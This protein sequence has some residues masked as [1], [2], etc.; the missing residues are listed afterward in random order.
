VRAAIDGRDPRIALLPVEV[1]LPRDV[2]RH[3]LVR[4]LEAEHRH[5]RRVHVEEAA[6]S[7]GTED[8]VGCPVD[9]RT[10]PFLRL[11]KR[12]LRVL[13]CLNVARDAEES[14]RDA[15]VVPQERRVRLHPDVRPVFPQAPPLHQRR[16]TPKHGEVRVAGELREVVGVCEREH[17][18][19][20]ELRWCE[21][22]GLFRG[23]GV[24]ERR[25][26]EVL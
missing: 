12:L 18:L 11:T 1:Q 17:V 21:P 4:R 2:D 7:R 5:H 23:S 22:E 25:S 3:Q 26:V 13:A 24:V 15:G 8:P 20:E 10:R 16:L 14:V 6:R 19:P 9:E